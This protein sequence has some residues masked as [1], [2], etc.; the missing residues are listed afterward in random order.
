MQQHALRTALTLY[1]RSTLDV[2]SAART[3]GVDRARLQ[4]AVDR[5]GGRARQSTADA[6]RVTV[7]AD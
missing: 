2:E 5:V 4:R 7:G 1:Q 6:E 3:A